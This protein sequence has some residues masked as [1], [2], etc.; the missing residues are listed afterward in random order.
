MPSG[1]LRWSGP[2]CGRSRRRSRSPTTWSTRSGLFGGSGLQF[3]A[4]RRGR[5]TRGL[6][7]R[8]A[9]GSAGGRERLRADRLGRRGRLYVSDLTRVLVTG[10]ISPKLERIYGVVLHAQRAGIAAI[11]PGAVMRDVDAAARQ[12]IERGGFWQAVRSWTGAR[13]RL[14]GSR[15]A[16][17]GAPT[18]PPVEAGMVVTVEPG[19]L[20]PGLGRRADRGRCLGDAGGPRSAEPAC[21]RSWGTA[22]C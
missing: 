13:D 3:H 6:A 14:G 7:A 19:D 20:L 12:V 21:R 11:R 8:H 16:A 2:R 1:R 17:A 22:W 4:D 18:R 10:R 5:A 9:V 15:A